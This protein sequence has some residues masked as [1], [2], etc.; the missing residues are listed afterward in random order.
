MLKR[1]LASLI[2]LK[3]LYKKR[4]LRNST[5]RF[6]F[7]SSS[8]HFCERNSEM[9][10]SIVGDPVFCPPIALFFLKSNI[11]LSFCHTHFH[12]ENEYMWFL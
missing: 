5:L 8:L 12:K 2:S 11:E 9:E 3:P 4:L 6:R 7:L 1:H 10:Q